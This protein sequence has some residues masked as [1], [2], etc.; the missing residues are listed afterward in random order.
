MRLHVD[1]PLALYKK[2]RDLVECLSISTPQ[3][4]YDEKTNTV[5]APLQILEV[6][7]K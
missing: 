3:L 2:Y 5:I 4:S 1:F 7:R 6:Y